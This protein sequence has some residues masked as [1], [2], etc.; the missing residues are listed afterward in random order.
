MHYSLDVSAADRHAVEAI[1]TIY[2]RGA[3]SYDLFPRPHHRSRHPC[4]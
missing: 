1:A 2:S 4:H 3:R